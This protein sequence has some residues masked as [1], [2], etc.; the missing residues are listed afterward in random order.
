MIDYKTLDEPVEVN[1]AKGKLYGIGTGSVHL[2]V[3]GQDGD[4]IPITLHKVLYVPGMDSNLLSCNVLLGKELEIS[5]HPTR[6]INIFL[7]EYIVAKTV[8]RGKLWRLKTV[9]GEHPLKTVGRKP[10]EPQPPKALPYEIWHHRFAHLGPWNL[11]KVQKLVD[12][13]IID[14]ATLPKEGYACKAC[15]SGSQTRNL[16]D[17]PMQ[18]RTVAGDRIH[19]DICGWIDPIALGDSRYFL[20]F[21]DDA[22]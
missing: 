4:I 16:S 6:G 9:D 1:T 2:T 8:P 11:Q 13:M 19:S 22:T 12:G 7:G 21:I 20:T 14:P 3:E 15:I 17:A 10:E 18:R 5:M